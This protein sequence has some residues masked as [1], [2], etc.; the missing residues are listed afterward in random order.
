MIIVFSFG[1]GI[2]CH[3]R[4]NLDA[5]LKHFRQAGARN[6]HNNNIRCYTSMVLESLN[7]KRAAVELLEEVDETAALSLPVVAYR[8]SSLYKALGLI[9]VQ[10]VRCVSQRHNLM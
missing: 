8:M 6:P 10:L 9:Q 3:K 7:Q 2:V 4:G 1:L 5:A